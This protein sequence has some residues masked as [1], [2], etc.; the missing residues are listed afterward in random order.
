MNGRHPDCPAA[1]ASSP[2]S[3]GYEKKYSSFNEMGKSC[4]LGRLHLQSTRPSE[5]DVCLD[6]ISEIQYSA[7]SDRGGSGSGSGGNVSMPSKMSVASSKAIAYRY[8]KTR[9]LFQ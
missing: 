1:Y 8:V 7:P 9:R 4:S 3:Y 2:S 6:A 5:S